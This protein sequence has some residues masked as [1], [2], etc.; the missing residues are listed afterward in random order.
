[1]THRHDVSGLARL[2]MAREA[3]RGFW[4]RLRA[5]LGV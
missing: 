2:R 5:L 1:M 3:R 4:G